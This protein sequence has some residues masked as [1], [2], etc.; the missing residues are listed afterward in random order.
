MAGEIVIP[1]FQIMIIIT[2][3]NNDFMQIGGYGGELGATEQVEPSDSLAAP[4]FK[5]SCPRRDAY[6][7]K[8]PKGYEIECTLEK[9]QKKIPG[10]AAGVATNK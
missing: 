1:I 4:S 9:S 3:E 7:P 2:I 10:D 6:L 8:D 5:Y